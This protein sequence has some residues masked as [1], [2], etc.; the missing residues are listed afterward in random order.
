LDTIQVSFGAG[1]SMSNCSNMRFWK[2]IST[3]RQLNVDA[4]NSI[5][6]FP[7][8]SYSITDSSFPI[9]T[10][11]FCN[12]QVPFSQVPTTMT[13]N[14]MRSG[15]SYLQLMATVTPVAAVF[16]TSLTQL[17]LS[18]SEITNGNTDYTFNFTISQQLGITP[19]IVLQ[20]PIDIGIASATC[21]PVTVNNTISIVPT[22]TVSSGNITIALISATVIPEGSVFIVMIKGVTNPQ[23]P[24]LYNFSIATYYDSTMSNSL[25]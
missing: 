11:F 24:I 6:T 17:N 2:N 23:Q 4:T 16:N 8:G 1:L 18:N 19:S 7:N 21:A 3:R 10:Y 9:S 14:F 25:V 13:M 12:F 22:C 20:F 5:F 15:S